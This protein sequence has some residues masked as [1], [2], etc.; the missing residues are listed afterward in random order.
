MQGW[1]NV[2]SYFTPTETATDSLKEQ[3]TGASYG[4]LDKTPA[5]SAEHEADEWNRDHEQTLN[6]AGCDD[7]TKVSKTESK[8]DDGWNDADWGEASS[9]SNESWS[10]NSDIKSKRTSKKGD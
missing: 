4:S 8:D 9:W 3:Q 2:Q 10:T 6:E 7:K 5:G 1:W